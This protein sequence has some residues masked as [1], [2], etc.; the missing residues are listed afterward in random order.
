MSQEN[1]YHLLN[2]KELSPIEATI[3]LMNSPNYFV[4]IQM[5]KFIF[6]CLDFCNNLLSMQTDVT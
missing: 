3:K 4:N 1:K 6:S 2:I 5:F